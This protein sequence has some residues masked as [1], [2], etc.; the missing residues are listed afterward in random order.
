M[1]GCPS[2]GNHADAA[3]ST[4]GRMKAFKDARRPVFA[5]F[6]QYAERHASL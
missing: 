4:C 2:L 5:C 3:Y 6:P 1:P